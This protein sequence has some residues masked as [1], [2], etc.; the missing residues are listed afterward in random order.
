MF[1]LSPDDFDSFFQAVHGH[2][3]YPWQSR[4]TR[5][6]LNDGKWPDVIDLPTGTGKTSVLD[7]AIFALAARPRVFP[8]RVVF[9]IDRRIVVDQVYERAEQIRDAIGGAT[10]GIL[11]DIKERLKDLTNAREAL[12]IAALRG[13]IPL[14]GEWFRR[15]DQPWVMVSTVDQFGSRLLFR[16]YGV[17][18]RMRSVHAGLA[19]NDCLV[20]LDEVH[21]SHAFASTLREVSS[22]GDI[23][24]L[25]SVG[26]G[27]PHRFQVVEMS[28]TPTRES[29]ARFSLRSQDL[30][31]SEK[32][33]QIAEAPKRATLVEVPGTRD[34]HETAPKT[35][36]NL[37][38]KEL[39]DD[40][41]SVGVIVNRVRTAREVHAALQKKGIAAHLVTGRM[42][43]IDKTEVLE[44]ISE[45]VDPDRDSP[46][47]EPTVIVA[48]Q[49]IEVGADFS[50][51]AL[52][53]EAAPIDSL[54]Q[55]LGR[56][57]RRGALAARRLGIGSS[58]W[59]QPALVDF[60]GEA[61]VE[62]HEAAARCWILGVAS[63]LNPKKPDP[64]YGDRA[65]KA[66]EAM[67]QI[68]QDDVIDVGPG[69]S[70]S[71]RLG[72]EAQ[73]AK[74]EAPLLL[75]IHIDAWSQTNP[76]P[77]IDPSIAEFLHGKECENEP[78]VSLL[79]RYDHSEQAIT[80]VPPRP[81]EFLSVSIS[82]VRNWLRRSEEPVMGD[83]A[84]D[85]PWE[86]PKRTRLEDREL[87]G[88][89]RWAR[90]E[91]V[92]ERVRRVE[93]IKPGDVI[94]VD[95]DFGGLRNGN[96]DPDHRPA[97]G[98]ISEEG[99]VEPWAVLD[100]GDEV[101]ISR[102][103]HVEHLE[104][105]TLRL[106]RRLF[107]GLDIPESPK[108]PTPADEHEAER[109]LEERIREWL[110]SLGELPPG[111]IP[112]WMERVAKQF[113]EHSFRTELVD[114]KDDSGYYVL[115]QRS[116][117]PT[118]LDGFDD[119]QSLTG[120]ETTLREHLAGVGGKVAEF[121]HSLSLANEV[122]EDLRLAAELHD[123]GK[124][125]CRFQSQ[126]C[127]HDS[128]TMAGMDEPLAKSLPGVRTK[129]YGWPPVRHEFTSVA[130]AQ[131]VPEL[132]DQ[133]HDPDLVLHLVGSHHG[134]SR[135]LPAIK[136][137]LAPQTLKL[138][139]ELVE[140]GF[141][142][143]V[144]DELQDQRGTSSGILE[145]STRSDLAE[146]SLALD[147]A[148]RFWRLQEKYGYHGLAWLEAI[149]RLADQQQSAEEAAR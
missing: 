65:R 94:I 30:E 125:D 61:E 130:L 93:Q 17:S 14:D 91:T 1:D 92:V 67:Q 57:D 108:M 52:I 115:V 119:Q 81:A 49:A 76:R 143:S 111:W 19:G 54:Q 136:E 101:Q 123:L 56:L 3:P 31:A 24:G 112:D 97:Q 72:R 46:Q 48:T 146:T 45:C 51:D 129:R 118:A 36:L 98:Q 59:V 71:G 34:A 20:I 103:R 110:S 22:N 13:G 18:E 33:K 35:V 120:T 9:V 69:T 29:G 70:L 90:G 83:V 27:L 126:M 55:R 124:V 74:S 100:V 82:A 84:L 134:Y 107:E 141:R 12:G 139:G 142:L 4:L 79:W 7:T 38:K 73:A 106:D 25:C 68:A 41:M 96:W 137:D 5:Q 105:A 127:G 87:T 62:A 131:S 64:V 144:D 117:D 145:L 66:W 23:P 42:R 77:V 135:P 147:M 99:P 58:R 113:I 78:D 86:S 114:G 32:L 138:S 89:A 75:P 132:L 40:E 21:L 128:V 88:V 44:K 148:D 85:T 10:E 39:W 121:G 102:D 6:V 37:V 43:P 26:G 50:F 80:L 8:R 15:P 109:S 149:L 133:A 16:G 60:E 95:P 116:V 63:A 2:A 122:I 47:S 11:L 53:T 104:R 28:A 140:G